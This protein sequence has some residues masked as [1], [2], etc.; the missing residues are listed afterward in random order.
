MAEKVFRNVP[1]SQLVLDEQFA[2]RGS[3]ENDKRNTMEFLG[4]V[5]S[6]KDHG[7]EQPML[8]RFGEDENGNVDENVVILVDGRQRLAAATKAGL[9]EVPVYIDPNIRTVADIIQTQI[10]CNIDRISQS[11]KE[12]AD[13]VLQLVKYRPNLTVTEIAKMFKRTPAWAS[14]I[15]KLQDGCDELKAALDDNL[16]NVTNAKVICELPLDQQP[17]WVKDF[18]EQPKDVSDLLLDL[19]EQIKA[20]K[21]GTKEKID[22]TNIPKPRTAAEIKEIFENMP[23]DDPRYAGYLHAVRLDPE[24]KALRTE[25]KELKALAKQMEK[26]KK[27]LEAQQ[28]AAKR[29]EENK[30]KWEAKRAE[31]A[32][33]QNTQEI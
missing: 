29:L 27:V 18:I 28:E 9:T 7:I 19:R 13:H 3:K 8:G 33:A 31:L 24:S 14:G 16:I 32:A 23:K 6:I 21:S 25:D 17:K 2:L 5:E 4:M 15:L 22:T 11:P 20:N 30:A 12:V 26:D 10:T 1:I